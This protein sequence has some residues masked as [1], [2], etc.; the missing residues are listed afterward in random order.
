MEKFWQRVA[1]NKENIRF[2]QSNSYSPY[3]EFSQNWMKEEH[4]ITQLGINGFYRYDGIM[5]SLFSGDKINRK[6]KEWLFDI[7]MHYLTE[8]EYRTGLTIQEF[9]VRRYWNDLERGI[10]GD[11]IKEIFVTLSSDNKYYIA[12]TLWRQSESRESVDKFAEALVTVLNCG[13]VYK[14]KWKQK[15]LLFY[16]NVK[17]NDKD[18]AKLKLVQQLFQPLGYSLHV[19]WEHHF[20]VV[21]EEQTMTIDEIELL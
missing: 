2:Y 7:Y 1:E 16:T 3:S 11:E 13:I 4:G 18:M 8:I 9:Q 21:G 14:N 6:W 17:K 5:Q 20:A 12:H 15:Q 19:L 10:Y